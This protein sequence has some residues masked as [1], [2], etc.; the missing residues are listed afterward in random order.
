MEKQLQTVAT[1][2]TD[3]KVN[4]CVGV[5]CQAASLALI[6]TAKC[7]VQAWLYYTSIGSLNYVNAPV[8]VLPSDG[9]SL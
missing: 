9:C 1:I 3:Q 8:T 5:Q 6:K 7:V 4:T 2:L